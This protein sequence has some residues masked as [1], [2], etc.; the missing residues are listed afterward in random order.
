MWV[1]ER[2]GGLAT[3]AY[4]L[5]RNP[6]GALGLRDTKWRKQFR[7]AWAAGTPEF[8]SFVPRGELVVFQAFR[9]APTAKRTRRPK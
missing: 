9:R 6:S 4:A 5:I 7:Y 8:L 3:R 2:T 1:G